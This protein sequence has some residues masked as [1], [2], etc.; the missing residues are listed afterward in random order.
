MK[1]AR[2]LAT[3]SILLVLLGCGGEE[4]TAA[5][6][7]VETEEQKTLYALGLALAQRLVQ[8]NLSE[9]ELAIVQNGFADGVLLRTP[10]VDLSVFGPQI[11]PKDTDRSAGRR[12]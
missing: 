1:I 8:F 9:D 12:R 7:T 4:G 2:F 3:I 6:V 5:Q 11:D 10:A